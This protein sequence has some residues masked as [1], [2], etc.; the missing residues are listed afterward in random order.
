M[1]VQNIIL[2]ELFKHFIAPCCQVSDNL[3]FLLLPFVRKEKCSSRNMTLSFAQ[4]KTVICK[5]VFICIILF[6]PIDSHKH[7]EY[8]K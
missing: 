8:I 3:I 1:K 4:Q 7:I 2:G 5:V 6:L